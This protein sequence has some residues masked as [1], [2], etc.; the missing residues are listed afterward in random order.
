MIKGK[1]DQV[2]EETYR[3]EREDTRLLYFLPE[4]PAGCQEGGVAEVVANTARVAVLGLV[5]DNGWSFQIQHSSIIVKSSKG[6]MPNIR[7]YLVICPII[8]VSV[9][10]F[11]HDKPFLRINRGLLVTSKHAC[12]QSFPPNSSP[13]QR[14][15]YPANSLPYRKRMQIETPNSKIIVCAWRSIIRAGNSCYRIRW[16][17]A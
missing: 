16:R 15:V 13:S 8:K 4:V 1:F 6:R 17:R 11:E 3:R 9:S 5:S 14:D 12:L 2:K 7:I 10:K